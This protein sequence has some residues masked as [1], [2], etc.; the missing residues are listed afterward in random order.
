MASKPITLDLFE[1]DDYNE[2]IVDSKESIFNQKTKVGNSVEE[3]IEFLENLRKLH[4]NAKA[5]QKA[6]KTEDETKYYEN[7]AYLY[8]KE[9]IR[10]LPE[11]WLQTRT[12][13]G[14]Y[15]NVLT[16]KNQRSKHKINEWSGLRRPELTNFINSFAKELPYADDLIFID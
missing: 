11:S 15:E 5:K 4:L 6:A 3:L 8:W 2:I 1:T 10:W 14:S 16:M 12:W 13:T 7:L 9:L